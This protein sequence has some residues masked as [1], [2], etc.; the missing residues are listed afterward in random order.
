[1]K[2][3][4]IFTNKLISFLLI[5]ILVV[6]Q[7][8][9]P[10][11]AAD[12]EEISTIIHMQEKD[13]TVTVYHY[14]GER[15]WGKHI[16]DI[17]VEVLPILEDLA[18]FPYSHDFNVV[19]YPKKSEQINMWNAQN[20][21]K[22]GIW[23]NRD[24]FTP[25]IIEK[26]AIKAVIIHENVHYWSN[27]VIYE[28]PWLKEG[29]AEFFAYLTL[30]RMGKK[31]DALH[32]KNDWLKTMEEYAYHNIPL[33]IF[34]YETEGPGNETTHLAYSKS[35]LFCLEIYEKYGLEPIQKINRYLHENNIAADSFMYMD[36][37]KDYTG[38][39]QKALFMEWVFPKRIN[40]EKWVTTRI[41]IQECEKLV[42]SLI[43]HLEETYG[44]DFLDF[45]EFHIHMAMQINKAHSYMKEYH[46]ENASQIISD[47]MEEIRK[48]MSQFDDYAALYFDAEKQ[49][50]SLRSTVGTVSQDN[51]L[52]A[53]ERLLSFEFDLF[54]EQL[55]DFCEEMKTVETYHGLQT[56]WC[57]GENCTSLKPVSE[58]LSS[59]S[60]E[61][62]ISRADHII[63]I[64][65][66]YRR[67]ERELMEHDWF[68]VLG[69]SVM[70]KNG[71][72]HRDL[73]KAQEEIKNGGLENASSI[74]GYIQKELSQARKCGIGIAIPIIVGLVLIFFSMIWKKQKQ[75]LRY[76]ME[77]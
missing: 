70:R 9:Q 43:D 54:H 65:Q 44:F 3:K 67:I 24:R 63:A 42:E 4:S 6:T 36:L 30:Q 12:L 23:I 14:I 22:K 18:G 52:A 1:M 51:L 50:H 13:V 62:A 76:L 71:N 10:I 73:E 72:F 41:E 11:T 34:E 64:I 25:E 5:G 2:I 27:N 28:K 77:K 20:L 33:D 57:A 21:M 32:K 48:I 45:V 31:D 58:L 35:A 68:T 53:R 37:L 8:P 56:E 66:E 16:F 55:R 74:L 40:L 46:F 47:E 17:T 39:D 69:I 60:Y 59:G 7:I 75:K 26:W 38:E 61:D 15:E 49:Y 19:I 29:F